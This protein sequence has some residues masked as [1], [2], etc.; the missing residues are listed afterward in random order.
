MGVGLGDKSEEVEGGSG[1]FDFATSRGFTDCVTLLSGCLLIIRL[2]DPVTFK[3][4]GGAIIVLVLELDL[5]LCPVWL[6][7][8]TGDLFLSALFELP[9]PV[10]VRRKLLIDFT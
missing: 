8:N 10:M 6:D 2:C 3:L 4:V 5:D 7:P 9:D 1:T